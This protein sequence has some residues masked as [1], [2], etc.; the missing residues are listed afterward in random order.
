MFVASHVVKWSLNVACSKVGLV[1]WPVVSVVCVLED[2]RHHLAHKPT[3]SYSP[4]A[5]IKAG[6]IWQEVGRWS[7]GMGLRSAL[8]AP[9]FLLGA[10]L[11]NAMQ[12]DEGDSIYEWKYLYRRRKDMLL[13]SCLC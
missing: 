12:C 7:P 11:I 8:E 5:G 3:A 13:N 10:F 4:P 1:R 9:K 2:L 6:D